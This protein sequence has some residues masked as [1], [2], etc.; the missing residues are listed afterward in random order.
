MIQITQFI[1]YIQNLFE[2]K[3]DGIIYKK[4]NIFTEIGKI[5]IQNFTK[6]L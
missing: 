6:I 4:K 2:I 1:E 3:L 5:L